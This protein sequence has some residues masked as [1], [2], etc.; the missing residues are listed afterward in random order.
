VSDPGG[1]TA[2]GTADVFTTDGRL[3][4]SCAQEA[5]VRRKT[6]GAL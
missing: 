5:M 3:V 6:T 4:A 1:G 2:F